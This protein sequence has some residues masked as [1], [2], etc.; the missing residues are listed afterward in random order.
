[1]DE[2]HQSNKKKRWWEKWLQHTLIAMLLV[3][4]IGYFTNDYFSFKK[5]VLS[6]YSAISSDLEDLIYNDEAAYILCKK[7]SPRTT[8]VKSCAICNTLDQFTKYQS[9]LKEYEMV[10]IM[11]TRYADINKR[12]RAVGGFFN[13]DTYNK[14]RQL[15]CWQNQFMASSSGLCK[16]E[17]LLSNNELD[18]WKDQLTTQIGNDKKQNEGVI[19]SIWKYLV[20]KFTDTIDERYQAIECNLCGSPFPALCRKK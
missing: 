17:V 19:Y 18:H 7:Y 4:L 9:G 1:M 16:S 20:Y 6:N 3:G 5:M 11:A 14:I 10:M 15:T 8:P 12:L 2:N 13:H